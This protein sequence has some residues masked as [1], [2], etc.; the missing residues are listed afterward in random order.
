[1]TWKQVEVEVQDLFHACL[2]S[3]RNSSSAGSPPLELE[4][5][6]LHAGKDFAA[7]DAVVHRPI[8]II[9]M[10]HTRAELQQYSTAEIPVVIVITQ[11]FFQTKLY[12]ICRINAQLFVHSNSP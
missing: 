10:A 8:L 7:A 3:T 11:E 2:A 4:S 6:E 9:N 1:V 5:V 12:A